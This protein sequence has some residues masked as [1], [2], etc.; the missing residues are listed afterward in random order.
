[1]QEEKENKGKRFQTVMVH[2]E[3]LAAS[4]QQGCDINAVGSPGNSDHVVRK[5]MRFFFRE[6]VIYL[7]HRQP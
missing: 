4:V 6:D 7:A 1:M 5:D 2:A 3:I